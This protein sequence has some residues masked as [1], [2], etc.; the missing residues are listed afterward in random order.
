MNQRRREND[1]EIAEL[2][3]EFTDFR[4]KI[5]PVI[6]VWATLTRLVHVLR[7]MGIA[8]KWIVSILTALGLVWGAIWAAITHYKP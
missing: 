3:R 4:N 1:D 2:R 7:W 6:E 5:E 8:A